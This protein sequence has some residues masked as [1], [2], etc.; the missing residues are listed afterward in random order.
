MANSTTF[1]ASSPREESTLC[2]RGRR[3]REKVV[4]CAKKHLSLQPNLLSR[5]FEGEDPAN[6]YYY[7]M[8]VID[9]GL[10]K[11]YRK[12]KFAEGEGD[13]NAVRSGA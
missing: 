6:L 9:D 13:D 2:A 12:C 1:P 4:R 3:W 8:R 10:P 5:P 11:S 7:Y